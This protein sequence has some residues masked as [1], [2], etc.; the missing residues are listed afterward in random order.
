M[1]IKCITFGKDHRCFKSGIEY[2]FE[3]VNLFVG[4]QGCGKSTLLNLM[5][6]NDKLVNVRLTPKGEEG[7]NS[8]FFDFES[9]NPRINNA[10][11]YS[12]I[13]GTSKGMGVGNALA[14]KFMSHG[15][16]L[17]RLSVEC[18]KKA[19]DCVIFLDEPE[20]ALSIRN[21]YKLANEIKECEKRNCQLFIATHCLPLIESQEKV[22][23]LEDKKWMKST[24]FIKRQKGL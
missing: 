9:G 11:E 7:V 15:E 20:T 5:R 24:K 21:Q 10:M 18:L 8:Y 12:N 3:N 23:S 19:K 16:A 14:S 1:Y 2:Q 13:D 4:D 17:L 22:L 6:D